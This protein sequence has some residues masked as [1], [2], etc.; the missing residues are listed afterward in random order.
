MDSDD[1]LTVL[2]FMAVLGMMLMIVSTIVVRHKNSG[3]VGVVKADR[4]A[5]SFETRWWHFEN[6]EKW[7]NQMKTGG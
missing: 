5:V 3:V 4:Q 6:D 2:M 1:R 7:K